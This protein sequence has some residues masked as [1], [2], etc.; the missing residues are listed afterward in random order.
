MVSCDNHHNSNNDRA[1]NL[2][3]KKDSILES[4]NSKKT[5]VKG[6]RSYWLNDVPEGMTFE[7]ENIGGIKDAFDAE[8][9]NEPGIPKDTFFVEKTDST[10]VLIDRYLSK[11]CE[12]SLPKIK[13][14]K[15]TISV[16]RQTI[17]NADVE[18]KGDSFEIGYRADACQAIMEFQLKINK[19]KYPNY[20]VVKFNDVNYIEL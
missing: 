7:S 20:K 14:L 10:L 9:R 18:F 5:I 15:D 19:L 8:L 6:S 3:W 16:N 11:G 12:K 2:K 13:F 17:I 1:S 4:L